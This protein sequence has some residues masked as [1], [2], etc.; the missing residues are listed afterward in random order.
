[1]VTIQ[2][3]ENLT[4][5]VPLLP[6]RN[7]HLKPIAKLLITVELPHFKKLIGKSV[8]TLEVLE[9]LKELIK[10]YKF[11]HTNVV[12]ST[13]SV[14]EFEVEADTKSKVKDILCKTDSKV[15]KLKNFKDVC[16][17]RTTEWKQNFPN[18]EEWNH[19]FSHSK[20][21][22]EAKPGERPDTIYIAGLP[23]SWFSRATD[24]KRPS[25]QIFQ[26]VFQQFGKIRRIDIPICDPYR[27]KMKKYLTG[28]N[29]YGFEEKEFFEGYVQ[30]YD[31]C[32]FVKTM[33]AFRGMKLVRKEGSTAYEVDIKV[34]YDKNKHLSLGFIKRR[35]ILCERLKQKEAEEKEQRKEIRSFL[36][37]PS[38]SD[39]G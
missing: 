14:I 27:S 32:G 33:D 37:V 28:M 9:K 29:S 6:R 15:I 34:D 38:K 24:E 23:I 8:S 4:D 22:D 36:N 25:E 17:I 26:E 1:M 21:M 10:P 12:T 30:F 31:Y 39:L 7:L 13:I 19:F 3:C 5:I 18:E 16:K 11:A 2:K 35:E 20:E